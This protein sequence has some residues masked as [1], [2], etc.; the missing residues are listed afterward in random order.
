MN[1]MEHEH[2]YLRWWDVF[3]GEANPL[4]TNQTVDGTGAGAS[5]SDQ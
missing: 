3:D 5:T 1:K 2:T 4:L